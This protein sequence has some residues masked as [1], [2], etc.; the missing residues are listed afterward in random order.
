MTNAFTELTTFG[1]NS[2]GRVLLSLELLV[3]FYVLGVFRLWL[4]AG[5]GRGIAIWRVAAFAG[6]VGALVVA[7]LSPIDALADVL[8]SVHM[9]QHMILMLIA[10]PLIV[11][12]ALPVAVLWALPR[13]WAHAAAN[14]LHPLRGVW[15]VLT[16]PPITWVIF[17]GTLWMWHLPV[18]YE[19]AL[20]D[21]TIHL[22]EHACFFTAAA[23]FWW[24]LFKPSTRKQ[25]QYGIN[26]LYLF[27]TAVQSGALGAL[28][29]FA[30]FPL[31]KRYA[32][33]SAAASLTPLGD[34]QLAGL[35]MWLP[36]GVLFVLLASA[37]FIAWLNAVEQSMRLAPN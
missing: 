27:T 13:S 36:G 1:W 12:S 10:A 26:I 15:R 20:A 22:L 11:V 7:L 17:A 35:I 9:T 3:G 14:R 21:S 18:L 23:L 31:Y 25:V 28:L 19:A 30:Q 29:T 16:M 34:Q 33:S 6:G 4:R 2:D 24:V 8:F 32:Q 5:R 37:Y